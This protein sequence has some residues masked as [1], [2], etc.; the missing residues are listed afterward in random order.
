MKPP[1]RPKK[2]HSHKSKQEKTSELRIIGGKWRSRRLRF[3]GAEGLRPTTDRV[4]ETL[5]N[6]LAP[7]THDAH[8][9]DVFSGSGALGLETLSRGASEVVFLEKNK[10]AAS[11]IKQNLE[12]LGSDKGH[13]IHTDSLNW[14]ATQPAQPFDIVFLDPPFHNGLLEPC[15]KLLSSQGWLADNALIYIEME[16]GLSIEDLPNNWHLSKERHAGQVII[17]LYEAH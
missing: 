10:V 16:Q 11:S 12:T 7:Y 1:R 9:L 5:F 13:V 14:L 3:T 8:C 6:W 2:P 17:Q 4:R 15:Y